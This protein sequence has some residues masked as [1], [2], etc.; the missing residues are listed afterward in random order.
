MTGDCTHDV[1]TSSSARRSAWSAE[2]ER[3]PAF[4]VRFATR[5]PNATNESGLGLDTTDFYASLLVAKTVQSVRLVGN[6]GSGILGDPTDGQRQNDV[7]TYGVSLARAV[8]ERGGARRRGQ[9]PRP[10]AQRRRRFRAA[11]AAD[12]LKFGGR[13]TRGPVRFDAAVVFGLTEVDPTVG[14]T[15]GFTYVFNAFTVP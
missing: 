2:G 4:G 9:R 5:L 3:R 13:Y 6:I 12:C 8:T 1:R 11:K 15:G 10:T 14:F 7:L